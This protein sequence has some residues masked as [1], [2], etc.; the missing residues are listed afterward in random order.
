MTSDVARR[1]TACSTCSPRRA[2]WSASRAGRAR[3]G[4]PATSCCL[5][6]TARPSSPGWRRCRPGSQSASTR[7]C[8]ARSGSRFPC[9]RATAAWRSTGGRRPASSPVRRPATTSR[10]SG[11]RPTSCTPGWRRAV[12]ARP[13]ELDARTDQWAVA[14]PAGVRRRCRRASRAGSA[15]ARLCR[16]GG[17]AR[18][19]ARRHR[20]RARA[21]RP[22]RPRGQRAARRVRR[23]VRDRPLPCLALAAVGG[24]DLRPRRRA[25]ARCSGGRTRRVA[26]GDPRQAMLRAALFRVFSDQP[27]DVGRYAALGLA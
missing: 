12:P 25:V 6:S 8:L 4:V 24:G 9:R 18:G 14:E 15:R 1:R 10:P 20:P 22:R 2:C 11:R 16:P 23:P 21:G 27:C 26:V 7:R 17:D 13:G 19:R 3:P 5:P